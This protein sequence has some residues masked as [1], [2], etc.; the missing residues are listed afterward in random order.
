MNIET[1]TLPEIRDVY[2]RQLKYDF[3]DDER[4]SLSLI[5]K[6][7]RE[8]RYLCCGIRDESGV[9][10]YAFFAVID[11]LYLFDYFAVRKDLR[12]TG[13]GSAFLQELRG[14]RLQNASCVL[15]EVEDPDCAD[16]DEERT[17]RERRLRF[18]MKNG[19][20]NTGARVQTFGVYFLILEIPLGDPHTREEAG[21]I[22]SR[23]YRAILPEHIYT[24]MIRII[25]HQ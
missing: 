8:G 13:I 12:G 3:P 11:Q 22:Y 19:L 9:A 10:A 15:L 1:L 24:R 5:E 4:K 7:L 16:S 20:R 17:V 14:C 18:Y 6:S 21:E 2:L 25:Q 23:I